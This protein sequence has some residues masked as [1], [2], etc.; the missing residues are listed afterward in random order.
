MQVRILVALRY[1]SDRSES[2][3]IAQKKETEGLTKSSRYD[4]EMGWGWRLQEVRTSY[5]LA[6]PS[7]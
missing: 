5:E 4:A 1:K 6:Q 2:S 7:S 3:K